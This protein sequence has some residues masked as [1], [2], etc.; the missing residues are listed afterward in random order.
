MRTRPLAVLAALLAALAMLV[1]AV[2]SAR[3]AGYVETGA[4]DPVTAAPPVSRP[5]TGHC[6]ATLASHFRSNAP[7]GAAQSFSGTLAPP[8]QCANRPWSK[9]VLGSTTS[10]SGRQFDRSGTL[11]V[12]GVTVWFGT[13]QEPGG[14]AP[15]TFSFSKDI[16]DFTALLRTPQPFSGGYVNY[17]DATYT[18][19]YDQTVR[20]VYYLA[21]A[22]HPAPDVPDRVVGAPVPDL[23]P[24]ARTAS[25]AVSG[26]P[27]NTTRARLDVTLKGNGC[28]EQW[29]TAVPDAVARDFPDAELCGSGSY[30]E[31]TVGLD[32]V[33]AGA[34]GTYPHIYSGGIVPTLWRPVLAIDTLDL[35]SESVDLTPFAGRLVDGHAHQLS[36]G[37]TPIGDTWNLTAAL[38]LW[39]DHHR[40]Q[41]SGAVTSVHVAAAPTTGTTVGAPS[42]GSVDYS[43]RA[44]RGDTVTGYVDTSAGRVV[45]SVSTGR[46]WSNTGTAS[47]Q[48]A[49]QSVR[50]QDVMT[51]RSVSRMGLRVIRSNTLRE[52][53]PIDVDYS[54]ADYTDDQNFSLTGTVRMGQ[55][56]ASVTT[57]PGRVAVRGWDWR[58]NSHGLLARAGG[59][60]SASDG[61]S[62]SSYVGTTDTG[63][64]YGHFIRTAH[65]RIVSDRHAG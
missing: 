22:R 40:A 36:F 44:R 25:V 13:T 53:Y 39:T 48:G 32:G 26:L 18:G 11:T 24:A 14:A 35:R 12:G 4:D 15:T 49:V 45:T 41:T 6:T 61:D 33:R 28:D 30:R 57:E 7:T 50:Q 2:P 59:I 46:V 63:S 3:A 17:T 38:F 21:D 23:T 1:W 42:G 31:A 62:T 20:V 43:L 27:R 8:R 29:F 60:T 10:V 54:A 64:L 47:D 58:V 55:V 52:S 34:V 56:V 37:I 9:V 65:G 16:T 5:G 19:V 51:T